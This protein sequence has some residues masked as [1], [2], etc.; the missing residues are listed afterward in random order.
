MSSPVLSAKLNPEVTIEEVLRNGTY[1]DDAIKRFLNLNSYGSEEI[2][3]E[4][5]QAIQDILNGKTPKRNRGAT[6][7]YIQTIVDFAS[8]GED[9]ELKE[10]QALM[11][12]ARGHLEIA[13]FNMIRKAQMDATL[14]SMAQAKMGAGQEGQDMG[15]GKGG[16]GDK[17]A[18]VVKTGAIPGGEKEMAA[19]ANPQI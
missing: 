17:N 16:G 3:S 9:L 7:L 14:L 18:M 12:F 15:G 11:D 10:F 6:D 13:A 1:G 8:D 19:A 4:A 2:I 5:H